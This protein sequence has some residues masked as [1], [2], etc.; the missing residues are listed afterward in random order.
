MFSG[1]N[2][3]GSSW[4]KAVKWVAAVVVIVVVVVCSCKKHLIVLLLQE[5]YPK[6]FPFSQF[7]P[8]IYSEVKEYIYA[9][10]QFSEDLNLR[11][12]ASR[13]SFRHYNAINY[14][15]LATTGTEFSIKHQFGDS[16]FHF[17]I[18]YTHIDSQEAAFDT[19]SVC[20]GFLSEVRYT[21]IDYSSYYYKVCIMYILPL[22]L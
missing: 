4:M 17:N 5:P 3:P 18:P 9:C 19:A 6:R 20:F 7:V 1:T 22:V 16:L 10:L 2:S 21:C 8:R 14:F 12:S 11:Y 15:M 13:S